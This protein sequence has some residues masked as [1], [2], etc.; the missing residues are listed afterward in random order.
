MRKLYAFLFTAF[1]IFVVAAKSSAQNYTFTTSAGNAI[2]PGTSL[3]AG[4]QGDDLTV[5]IPLPFTYSVY[6]IGY[7][8]VRAS[9]N[10]NLQF[11]GAGNTTFSN[12]CPLP[13]ATFNT[14]GGVVFMPHWDD[15]H[16]GR[17][18]ATDGIFTSVTGSAPNRIFNIEW[19]G[20]LFSPS[21][22]TIN[23][24]ARLFEGQQ[25]VDF[26]YGTNTNNGSSATVGVQGAPTPTTLFTSFSCNTAASLSS[27]LGISFVLAAPCTGVPSPGTISGPASIICPGTPVTLTLSGYSSGG[28]MTFQWAS[29]AA[30]GGP[31]TPIA[32][33][34]SPT[35]SFTATAT[36]YYICTVTCTISGFAA[37]TTQ[38]AVN[39]NGIRHTSVT[40]TPP[41]SCA[42][43]NVTI[44]GTAADG[45]VP[46]G[47]AIV[48]NSGTINLPIVDNSSVSSSIPAPA[49]SI[50]SAANLRVRINATHT[51]VGDVDFR[52]T[53]PCG[54]TYLFDRPGLN[55]P[56]TCCGSS[57][58]L[59]AGGYVFDVSAATPF[60]E[61][62]PNP[63]PL[64]TYIPTNAV[65]AANTNWNA[66]AFPCNAPAGNWT[67]TVSDGAGGDVGVL[68]DWQ[69]LTFGIGVYTHTLTGPGT[70]TQNPSTGPNNS[71][72]NFTVTGIPAGT[73]NYN[74]TSTDMMGCSVTTPVAVTVNPIP[75]ILITTTPST[76]NTNT[77]SYTGPAVPIPD[78]TPAGV[79]IP[80]AVSGLTGPISDLNFRLD[81]ASS[82]T[83]DNTIGN[84][85]ASVDHTWN[86]DLIFR[87]TSPG[88][89][90]LT[91]IN[92][93]GGSGNNF[94]TVLLD[95]DGGFPATSTMSTA[96]AIS[97]NFAPESPLSVFDG[98]NGNGTWTLNV[99]DNAGADLGSLRRF[100]L[101]IQTTSPPTICNGEIV[102]LDAGA[103]PGIPQT[104][105]ST[106]PIIIPAAGNGNPYPGII[107]VSGFPVAGV[108]VRSVTI[109]NYDHTFPDDVDLV[110]V[111]PT[112]TPVILMSDC[113]GAT[114]ATGQNFTFQDGAPA[115]ADATFNNTGTY[116]CTNFL[117]PDNFP[118]PGPGS[119]TQALP[120][121]SSFSGNANG[122]WKLY[123]VDDAGLNTGFIGEWSITFNVPGPVTFS[124]SPA[125]PNSMFTDALATI[126]YT[127]TLVNTIW[128]KPPVT[129]TYTV[130]G[131]LLG[132]NGSNSVTIP[133][134]QLPAITAH[135]T[136]ASQTVCPGFTVT[137]TVAATGTGITYQW[138]RNGVNLSNGGFINGVNTNTLV[139]SFVSATTSGTY[140]CVVSGV[141]APPAISNGAVLT[142]ATAPTI[143]TQ[144]ANVT[145]CSGQNASF[146]VVAAGTPAPNIYQ[147]QLST[148][149]GATWNNILTGSAFTPTLSL[150]N[151]TVTMSGNR[152]RCIITNFCGQNITSGSATLTVNATPTVVATDMF[153]QR[154]CLSDTLVQLTG[155]PAGGSWSGIG[156]SGFNFVPT[157]TAVGT[158]VLT[159][160]YTSA[161]GCTASDTTAVKVVDCPER[162]RLLSNN[163]V[164]LYPNPNNGVFNIRV[165]STLYN[166]L[167]MKVYDMTGRLVNGKIV[168][169]GYHQ[170]LVSPVFTGLVYGRV[171]PVNL[172]Y[173]PSGTYLVKI[174]YDDGAR[175]SEKG[176]LVVIQR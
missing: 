86:G 106:T 36:R 80:L 117:T 142:V 122:D 60:P 174:Y 157:A 114:P 175:S 134:N 81:A 27:G 55:P 96:G 152:Y 111:S 115:L 128:V 105:T 91:L 22:S 78:A 30:S 25:R 16:T 38:F 56:A 126:A 160:T 29:S 17:N 76:I 37:N 18:L 10:G 123:A 47:F 7:T 119:L 54:I 14:Q 139:L 130:N 46:S 107:N 71:T 145:V 137:Y 143:S 121:L 12:T 136:P 155:T 5:L 85:N 148:D 161:A 171:I 67:L 33:A 125:A 32:G 66:I 144:P 8:Q 129:T 120:T 133:V 149:G 168:K 62:P 99:S 1:L 100:S 102:R 154:V 65:G 169:D 35:Y 63:V 153:N 147:W 138:R 103:L 24:E 73:Y 72:G 64:G 104:L 44:T 68:I 165:N 9:S 166:Y 49:L 59:I 43:G 131:S 151:V 77:F 69:I 48:A 28:G 52:L 70:I 164:I 163:G 98:Q 19:R 82:G 51:W 39:V 84:T 116:R 61:A 167:G 53:S 135:P 40:A 83:C 74:F 75:S 15:L 90:T 41:V 141:C 4:S 20:Q 97:G 34:T 13:T 113:G 101:I 58:D 89:T 94:C 173:L 2:V 6:N 50:S 118:S 108:T 45:V 140:D 57:S 87:L 11:T 124:Q 158:Y 156:V 92:Q 150:T 95:D 127:G 79:N 112:G 146:S 176:F 109:R 159:Y 42:P 170:S 132:C 31:Y 23:F 88:G 3:V 21:G 162:Q 26:I 93:R 110:L 172:S